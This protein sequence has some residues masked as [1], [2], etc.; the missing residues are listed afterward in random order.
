MIEQAADSCARFDP[1]RA[2]TRLLSRTCRWSRR[3]VRALRNHG[4]V[5]VSDVSARDGD[6]NVSVAL[7]ATVAAI[8]VATDL[9]WEHVLQ[10][11]VRR[12]GLIP[13]LDDRRVA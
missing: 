9:A 12:L 7:G 2:Q 10:G 5:S 1:V 3:S 11:E 6:R 8:V 4:L 13:D